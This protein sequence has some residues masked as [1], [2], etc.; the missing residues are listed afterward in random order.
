MISLPSIRNYS[1][2]KAWEEACWKKISN[3]SGLLD[4]LPTAHERH[5]L[6]MRAAVRERLAQGR[7]YKAISRE[8][9]LSPQTISAI[10]K[11]LSEN[12]Y[13]TYRERSGAR[14][15]K[16]HKLLRRGSKPRLWR[17]KYGTIRVPRV[18]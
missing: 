15:G 5:N 3:S 11:A 18:L 14:S 7:S 9:W 12:S 4:S 17:T 6:I 13:R 16:S 2:R 8:L 1:S 10:K